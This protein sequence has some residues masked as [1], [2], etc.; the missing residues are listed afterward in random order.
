MAETK[1][2]PTTEAE[3][4]EYAKFSLLI[5]YTHRA[6]QQQGRQK[7]T[8]RD[9]ITFLQFENRGIHVK[10]QHPLA[11]LFRKYL[12]LEG[13]TAT[14][15]FYDNTKPAG[16]QIVHKRIV[17][18]GV[19]TEFEN[20]LEDYYDRQTGIAHPVNPHLLSVNGKK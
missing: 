14:A 9:D 20:F 17:R 3:P 2:N 5:Y 7:Q 18:K 1:V 6:A 16:K 13:I 10:G 8:F 4:K 12:E 15:I 19:V 11:V